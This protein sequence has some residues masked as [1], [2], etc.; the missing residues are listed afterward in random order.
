MRFLGLCPEAARYREGLEERR[1]DA[2]AHLQRIVALSEIHGSEAVGRALRDA[3]EL[4]AFSCEYIAN[5]LAQ[6]SR[7]LPQAGALHLTRASDLLDLE[8][9]EPDLSIYETDRKEE[10]T[11]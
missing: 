6:R 4:G 5:L 2:R 10:E 1:L 7:E 9:P 11:K 3:L 8:L